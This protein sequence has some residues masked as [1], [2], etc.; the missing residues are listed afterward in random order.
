M[1]GKTQEFHLRFTANGDFSDLQSDIKRIES[2]LD[3]IDIGNSGLKNSLHKILNSLNN[4]LDNFATK[5]SQELNTIGDITALQKSEKKITDLI[6][7]LN[8]KLEQIDK[9]K[10]KTIFTGDALTQLN[11]LQQDLTEAENKF[12]ELRNSVDTV[13][14]SIKNMSFTGEIKAGINDIIKLAKE[15]KDTSKVFD[16]LKKKIKS[17]DYISN[18]KEVQAQSKEVQKLSTEYEKLKNS[19]SILENTTEAFKTPAEKYKAL[20]NELDILIKKQNDLREKYK[21]AHK[22]KEK[23]YTVDTTIKD[24][25]DNT[26][27]SLSNDIKQVR[28]EIS[29][30]EDSFNRFNKATSEL[31]TARAEFSVI[32]TALKDAR[33]E[34]EKLNDTAKETEL[35]ELKEAEQKIQ[36]LEQQSK[37]AAEVVERC[38]KEVNAFNAQGVKEG[39]QIFENL[40]NSVNK[41]P[42][43]LDKV[44]SGVDDVA[45]EAFRI[46]S[47]GDEIEDV[48]QRALQ[49]FSLENAVD[50]FRNAVRQAFEAVK[51]L[52]AAMTEIAVVTEFGVGD[53]WETLPEYTDLANKMG[54]SIAGVYEVAKLYYQQGLDQQ[55]VMKASEATLQM[56]R[57]GNL[58]YAKSTDYMTA[59]IQGFKLEMEDATRVNDVFSKLA[60]ITAA[61]T[62]EIAEALTR[63]AS[64]ANS[65]GMELE[66][67]SAFLTQMIETTRES[68][69][70]L[71]TA[72]KTIIARFQ[73][74]KKAPGDIEVDGEMVNVNKV[75]EALRTVGVALRDTNGQFRDLDDVFIELSSKWQG[76]DKNTQRYI[77]TIA[78]GSR[79]QSRFIA[80]MD[81]Y[82][83]TV[84]LVG[85]AYNSAG[86]GQEQ[87][88]KTMDSLESKLNKLKNAWDEF[89]TGIANS[90]FIKGG[91]DLL[92]KILT[93]VNDLTDG[94]GD[95]GNA[96]AKIGVAAGALSISSN[97]LKKLIGG[98]NLKGGKNLFKLDIG[99]FFKVS[100][101]NSTTE[102][103]K[104]EVSKSFFS[105][106]NESLRDASGKIDIK[107]FKALNTLLFSTNKGAREAAN[108]IL[109]LGTASQG[110]SAGTAKLVSS[111]ATTPW[112][113]IAAAILAVAA[114]LV[115]VGV[116]AHQEGLNYKIEQAEK[117]TKAAK[118]AA[119]EAKDSYNNLLTGLNEYD[120]LV[121]NLSKLIVGTDDWALA[122]ENTN[123]KVLEL[124]NNY[125]ELAQYVSVGEN[126]ELVISNEGR[127]AITNSE[128]E[129]VHKTTQALVGSQITED[130]YKSQKEIRKL[131]KQIQ[132]ENNFNLKAAQ[133][134]NK[135]LSSGKT[136]INSTE[137]WKNL[138]NEARQAIID[139]FGGDIKANE[140]FAK[141]YS[142]GS[143]EIPTEFRDD[144]Q[145][146]N[147]LL[148]EQEA[149]YKGYISTLISSNEELLKFSDKFGGAAAQGL[150][151]SSENFN[152]KIAEHLEKYDYSGWEILDSILFYTGGN[153]L[154]NLGL[155]NEDKDG[156]AKRRADFTELAEKYGYDWKNGSGRFL[157]GLAAR[158]YSQQEARDLYEQVFNGQK[159]DKNLS[160]EEIM[161]IIAEYDYTNQFEKSRENLAIELNNLQG[162]QAENMAMFLAEDLGN[163]TSDEVEKWA[164]NFDLNTL[165]A[166]IDLEAI[167]V[168]TSKSQEEQQKQLME[169]LG[170]D[171]NNATEVVQK[172]AKNYLN[173]K[174]AAYTQLA[175]SLLDTSLGNL[176]ISVD[177]IA[178]I[179]KEIPEEYQASMI[180]AANNVNN[181]LGTEGLTDYWN[182]MISAIKKGNTELVKEANNLI[183]NIDWSNPIDQA[184]QLQKAMNSSS[185]EI[186]NLA[187]EL[188][189]AGGDTYSVAEQFKYLY[190]SSS[191][192][193]IEEDIKEMIEANGK[194]TSKNVKD[195]T[196]KCKD[197]DKI[198][199]QNKVSVEALTKAL[200]GLA[201]GKFA[202][203]AITEAT[204]AA[205]DAMDSFE[206]NL[207]DIQDFIDNFD[208]GLDSQAGI[209][210]FNESADKVNE[211]MEEFQYANPQLK[212][213]IEAAFGDDYFNGITTAEE[214]I[215]KLEAAQKKLDIWSSGNGLGFWKELADASV[216]LGD[217]ESPLG[218]L[219]VSWGDDG[220]MLVEIGENTFDDLSQILQD[221]Y[222]LSKAFADA[223]VAAMVTK[224]PETYLKLRENGYKKAIDELTNIEH[225]FDDKGQTYIYSLEELKAIAYS[226]GIEVEQVISDLN[227]KLEG[228][229]VVANWFDDS[230]V[231]LAGEELFGQ[232]EKILN[233]DIK[234]E[235][236]AFDLLKDLNLNDI[237]SDINGKSVLNVEALTSALEQ[238]RFNAEQA[239]E[240]TNQFLESTESLA[241]VNFQYY[242][243]EK[244]QLMSATAIG[245][246]KEEAESARDAWLQAFDTQQLADQ[247]GNTL[248]SA[249]TSVFDSLKVN[250]PG[251]EIP[252]T[253]STEGAENKYQELRDQAIAE[254]QDGQGS[255]VKV[256]GPVEDV[257]IPTK[258]LPPDNPDDIFNNLAGKEVDIKVNVETSAL[259][260]AYSEL[261]SLQQV[262]ANLDLDALSEVNLGSFD[263]LTEGLKEDITNLGDQVVHI[264]VQDDGSVQQIQGDIN[265]LPPDHQVLV[266]DNGT[267]AII[268]GAISSLPATHT[269][270]VV[271]NEVG[272]P[273][274]MGGSTVS[275]GYG[276]HAKGTKDK[277]IPAHASGVSAKE[278]LPTDEKAL[279][280]EEGPELAQNGDKAFVLGENGPEIADLEK[281]TKIWSHEDSKKILETNPTVKKELPAF[282]NGN[283]FWTDSEH[284]DVIDTNNKYNGSSGGGGGGSVS[285]DGGDDPYESALDYYWNFIIKLKKLNADLEDL[286]NERDRLLEKE[287][288]ALAA[289]DLDAVAKAQE[290]LAKKNEDVLK[291]HQ[292][293]VD[294]QAYYISSL[295]GGMQKL[296]GMMGEYGNAVSK[297]DGVLKVNWDSYNALG[298]DAKE[299]MD[300]LIQEWEDYYDRLEESKDAIQEIIDY[301]RDL[302]EEYRDMH[303]EAREDF[304]D[305]IDQ[306]KDV[307]V[308]MREDEIKATEEY[309]DKLVGLDEDYLDALRRN[310]DERRRLRDREDNYQEL[311]EKQRRLSLLRRDSS[312]V[313]KNEIMTLEEEIAAMQQDLAD[314]ETDNVLDKMDY[315]LQLKQEYFTKSIELMEDALEQDIKNGLIAQEAERLL[316]EAPEEAYRILTECNAEYLEMS[317][318]QQAVFVEELKNQMIEMHRFQTEYYLKMAEEM[319]AIADVILNQLIDAINKVSVNVNYNYT[320]VGSSGG[321]GGG[322]GGGGGGG[323]PGGKV[324]TGGGGD[325]HTREDYIKAHNAVA[326]G[327]KDP[328][329]AWVTN[330]NS[331]DYGFTQDYTD[332]MNKQAE[333]SESQRQQIAALQQHGNKTY[334]E[335]YKT[336]T[337]K[338]YATGGYVK[339]TGPAWVDGTKSKPEAF[340]SAADTRNFEV[341]KEVLDQVL[342]KKVSTPIQHRASEKSDFISNKVLNAVSELKNTIKSLV[343]PTGSSSTIA[344]NSTLKN[345]RGDCNIYITVD[346]ISSDYSVDRAINRVKEQILSSSSYRNVNLISRTR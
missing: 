327:S 79:Q 101:G 302:A 8:L 67:T 78:A 300:G 275:A 32:E 340:L 169:I 7:N 258:Y 199:K 176:D 157:G 282:R 339:Y 193:E 204:L 85:A 138:S 200:M 248:L 235:K 38:V 293:V 194:I 12:N 123:A 279:V 19:I 9:N 187:E 325:E 30:L 167:G 77:A 13:T 341:L 174:R 53:V 45:E 129:K 54:A 154:G 170:K 236:G 3:K 247:I 2:S 197:L 196:K 209:D 15:G 240:V 131:D 71:G 118:D 250:I 281:G 214:W 262:A 31:T 21:K 156:G 216:K 33:E 227:S 139:S 164:N 48:Y 276:G 96:L 224:S 163:M 55:E 10:I 35:S 50:L 6:T 213:Y 155:S 229:L 141:L 239:S 266:S 152:K 168:D 132:K 86:A 41:V 62:V 34:F 121:S 150:F 259:S 158:G 135:I 16:E 73:E 177:E 343:K 136:S 18:N 64:I 342:S 316:R 42:A 185:D 151:G 295:N 249:L 26:G 301:Y 260:N 51:E 111:L 40:N 108:G 329:Y 92:T 270:T 253:F 147:N 256:N 261:E 57:V 1:A 335:A 192:D 188:Y 220:E 344:S 102:Q 263:D 47:V 286:L 296:E 234:T 319:E 70:N 198:L 280:G 242:D 52:D 345:G 183:N 299:K 88:E 314:Q 76:L 311:S 278:G 144:I 56:A 14:A 226:A 307:M 267:V 332:K 11:K 195:L 305:L 338:T 137:E 84:E 117:A 173:T 257:G 97:L 63:T 75:E 212:A 297:V 133:E 251:F 207:Q 178:D 22:G 100:F 5:A 105:I 93:L 346:E 222:G 43:S 90:D 317:T 285:S 322:G 208:P 44:K 116:A 128:R 25:E 309:Y 17:S 182:T 238:Y 143:I 103:I 310:V 109:K 225:S 27:L 189:D 318:T 81:N 243:M 217:A 28:N 58:D 146:Y 87:Y 336:V 320:Y 113:W 303:D 160:A 254:F 271:Y 179:I 337:G 288:R 65:A 218:Q 326:G 273:S 99:D 201:K 321:S 115:A 95:I 313:Y 175:N 269:V 29:L 166:G 24:S 202:I 333:L 265:D 306:L 59:A 171:A 274:I 203:D 304:S 268:S 324:P 284:K 277:F 290:A 210:F 233:R 245:A 145:Q 219:A 223:E 181:V 112:G 98:I 180:Q 232:I 107:K 46:Q 230:G 72:L 315:D 272:K 23:G 291:Q 237:I 294:E 91:I 159:A 126:G 331:T 119:D 140:L 206:D 110:A 39:Q 104:K 153:A 162:K 120:G 80:M 134:L 66:T 287:A 69:E 191:F 130:Y 36:Q 184:Y 215:N 165:F 292:K 20:Q 330:A 149:T 231:A 298:D 124:L 89:T 283:T 308:Q 122:L 228:K 83:R 82:D 186:K 61:D 252:I 74:M 37:Q 255:E 172:M 148:K 264:E 328:Q 4:E 246:T 323:S 221:T 289:G 127:Q 241:G 106:L 205:L 68:P 190:E 142:G 94:F 60:A 161:A 211:F 244:Q 312:G 114:A 125:K 49:F 334:A